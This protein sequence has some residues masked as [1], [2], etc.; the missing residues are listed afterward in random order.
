MSSKNKVIISI[1]VLAILALS[2]IA[3]VVTIFAF[4]QQAFRASVTISYEANDIVGKVEMYTK[5]GTQ[6]EKYAG[7]IDFNAGTT[8]GELNVADDIELTGTDN[9]LLLHY[10]FTN[11]G[12]AEYSAILNYNKTDLTLDNM[13]VK[14][15][16]TGAADS[17]TE[18]GYG[19]IVDKSSQKH[20]YAEIAVKD[21]AFD[22]SANGFLTW[23][24]EKYE[25]TLSEQ[26]IN[27]K[28]VDYID[29]E[30]GTYSAR[31]NGED[32]SVASSSG[33][34]SAQAIENIWYV[35]SRIGSAPIVSV[36]KSG[37]D[38]NG[39]QI[40]LPANTKVVIS[41]GV[42]TIGVSAFNNS[43]GL[44][45][46][47]IPNTITS[48]ESMAFYGCS[49]LME[50]TIPKSVVSLGEQSLD[51][52]MNLTKLNFNANL[53]GD[54]IF[55][56]SGLGFFGQGCVVNIGSSV[57]NLKAT[58]GG[59]KV[60]KVTID[61]GVKSICANAFAGN[62]E[63]IELSLPSTLLS[64]GEYAFVS[65]GLTSVKL[66]ENLISIG[67][68]AFGLCSNLT[69]VDF[70]T[71]ISGWIV[72]GSEISSVDLANTITAATYLK[73]TYESYAWQKQ[74]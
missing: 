60:K 27:I 69:S 71:N 18:Y 4:S 72:N 70:G 30:D 35:P 53:N 7:F 47:S 44:I 45:N 55:A 61:E 8:G 29:N 26:S 51:Y 16:Q 64:I 6:E 67:R 15:S 38:E 59:G 28:A 11:N 22:A 14:Y 40:V 32:I 62:S 3:A 49:N 19:L 65:T 13:D 17:Y 10:V 21:L 52:C 34:L 31:Y 46:V 12:D 23:R 56:I 74:N 2:A 33:E 43:S 20:Y 42:S 39:N 63:L 68:N 73:Q 25:P 48:I 5:L 9:K 58:F 54:V 24:L 1:S 57:T 37:T 66:P 36:E 41:E 50:L